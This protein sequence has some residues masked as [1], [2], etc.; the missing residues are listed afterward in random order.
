MLRIGTVLVLLTAL[1]PLVQAQA[2]EAARF[3]LTSPDYAESAVLARESAGGGATPDVSACGGGNLSPAL[4]W[5]NVP[6]GTRSFAVLMYDPDGAD[7]RGVA[8][9]VAYGIAADVRSLPKA[10]LSAPSALFTGGRNVRNMPTYFGPCPPK[11]DDY[12]H[13]AIDVIAL[14]LPPNAL[15]PG[16]TRQELQ[17][18]IA[19]HGLGAAGLVLRYRR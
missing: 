14:D 1:A 16:L 2:D 9:L 18:R 6:S 13:Y 7:G 11:T 17:D 10:A 8:H 5:S 12:H 4:A 15:P 3:R 19:G